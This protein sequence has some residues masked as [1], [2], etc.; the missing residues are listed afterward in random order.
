[1]SGGVI[2]GTN[3]TFFLI[4]ED[5]CTSNKCLLYGS[6]SRKLKLG[7]GGKVAGFKFISA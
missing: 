6:D 3:S 2:V 4:T 1:M 5:G 7:C